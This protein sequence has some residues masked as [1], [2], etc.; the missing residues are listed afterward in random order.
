MLDKIEAELKREVKNSHTKAETV[1]QV[2]LKD[3]Y[4]SKMKVENMQKDFQIVK[5]Y[6][7]DF[8][9]FMSIRHLGTVRRI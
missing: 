4:K 9:F 8:Q 5:T 2:L 7:S 6:A 3:L 1:I